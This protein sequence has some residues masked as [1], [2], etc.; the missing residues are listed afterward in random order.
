MTISRKILNSLFVL[1]LISTLN[2]IGPSAA[3]RWPWAHPLVA[4]WAPPWVAR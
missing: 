3:C 1:L 4:R 2:P